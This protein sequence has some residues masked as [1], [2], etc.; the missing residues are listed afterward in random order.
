[1][2]LENYLLKNSKEEEIS[3]IIKSLANDLMIEEISF[4]LEFFNK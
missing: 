2:D 3:T 4:S 1:M